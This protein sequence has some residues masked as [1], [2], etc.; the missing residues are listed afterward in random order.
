M[1][2]S[3]AQSVDGTNVRGYSTPKRWGVAWLWVAGAVFVGGPTFAAQK[4]VVKTEAS[5]EATPNSGGTSQMRPSREVE[6]VVVWGFRLRSQVQEQRIVSI[7]DGYSELIT[8]DVCLESICGFVVVQEDSKWRASNV[9]AG[10]EQELRDMQQNMEREG[11]TL[12][13]VHPTGSRR[14]VPV[15]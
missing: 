9:L 7:R 13:I 6:V 10:S 5:A 4:T 3:Q 1:Q 8:K 15:F 2:C 11:T 12:V 14:Q